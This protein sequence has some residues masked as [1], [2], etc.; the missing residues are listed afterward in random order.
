MARTRFVLAAMVVLLL[1]VAVPA[2]GATFDTDF[3][4]DLSGGQEVPPVAT[5]ATGA[6]RFDV[7]DLGGGKGEIRFR[8][9][10]FDIDN[11]TAAHIHLGCPGE[12]GD[13][14][15]FLF[16]GGPT[17]TV[18]G[19]L[20]QGVIR[21]NNLVGPLAGQPLEAL[22]DA[23]ES[24]CTYVNVHTTEWPGGEIRGQIFGTSPNP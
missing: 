1:A 10:V 5:E 24:N 6:A 20:S 18:N 13:V 8:L 2:S 12:N 17:G 9:G 15:A 23:M 22:V 7:V 11:V 14:V 4:A 21:R 19:R 16:S 3:V